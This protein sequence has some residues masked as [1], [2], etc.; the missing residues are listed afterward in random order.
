VSQRADGMRQIKTL[1]ITAPQVLRDRLR[2]LSNAQLLEVCAGL[3]P[4]VTRVGEPP[5]AAKVAL[6]MLGC[7]HCALAAEVADLDA[8]IVPL[9]EE[10]NPALLTLNGVGPDSAGQLLVTA[11]QNTD[12]LRSEG[13]FAM[14][15][16]VAPIPASS[17]RTD[18]HRLNRGGD[19]QANAALCRVVLSRMPRWNLRTRAYVERRTSQGLSKKDIIRCLKRLIAR[20]NYYVLRRP[21]DPTRQPTAVMTT[22][23]D[24]SPEL[25]VSRSRQLLSVARRC[26]RGARA[27][28]RA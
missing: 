20:E 13:A 17:G 12:R 9:I 1:I 15:C 7:P 8:L 3:R 19:R 10:I 4:E 24:D 11:G 26:Q 14:L 22:A 23:S 28:Q 18:R 25:A 27:A 6:R 5:E 21:F 16:G 2:V